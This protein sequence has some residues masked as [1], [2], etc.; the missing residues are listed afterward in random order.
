MALV[1]WTPRGPL[2]S[3]QEEL[4][5]LCHEFSRGGNGGAQG[6]GAGAWAPPVD[7]YE[8]EDALVRTAELPG[9][10]TDDVSLEVHHHT[11]TLRGE[12]TP[13]AEVKEGHYHRAE[14]AYGPF[15]RAFALP[16][17]VDQEEVQATYHDGLLELRLPT[18]DSAK[19]RRIAIAG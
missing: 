8:T 6:W 16:T 17:L 14:R 3:V 18:L 11:L 2:R 19:P 5:R 13:D 1:R 4:N 15:Q 12:R 7:I 9:V 10:S